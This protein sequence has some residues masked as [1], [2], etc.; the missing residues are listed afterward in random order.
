MFKT[1]VIRKYCKN[2]NI[3][4]S[5]YLIYQ[6]DF[7]QVTLRR[8]NLY[9]ESTKIC[10]SSYDLTYKSLNDFASDMLLKMGYH[11]YFPV[12]KSD[13]VSTNPHFFLNKTPVQA[14]PSS[15]LC[16]INRQRRNS[17][18]IPIPS[19]IL[20]MSKSSQPKYPILPVHHDHTK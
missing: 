18:L 20:E 16:L 1:T 13:K 5:Q 10:H 3:S 8:E 15:T 11:K 6:M 12:S 2:V 14:I 4:L 17:L 9:Q 7:D 19:P